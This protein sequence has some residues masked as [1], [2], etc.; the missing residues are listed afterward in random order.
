MGDC[1]SE[2][3]I[4]QRWIS[5]TEAALGLGIVVGIQDRRVVLSFPAAQEERTYA[6]DNAP[7][8]RIIYQIGDGVNNADGES[9]TITDVLDNNHMMIYKVENHLGE[10]AVL[11]ELDL[12]CFVNF[13]SPKDRLFSGILDPN[14]FF[15]LRQ[16]ALDY[17]QMYQ[18]SNVLGLLGP[19]VQLLPHQLYIAK[20]VAKQKAPRVLLADEVGLGK[21]IEAGLI[22][23][24]QL[25]AGLAE[26]VLILVPDSLLHQWLVEMLRRFNLRFSVFDED[27]CAE[28]HGAGDNPFE[29]AQYVLCPLSFLT[30]SKERLLQAL[31]CDWDLLLVDEAHHLEWSP[32]QS[33]IEYQTVEQLAAKAS[34]VLL[35]TATPEQLGLE[36]HFA[37]LHLLD[38]SRYYDLKVFIEEEAS[39]QP[40][41]QLL[42]K[43]MKLYME[44]GDL[45]SELEGYLLEGEWPQIQAI[46]KKDKYQAIEQVISTLL[47]RHG[48]GRILFR[49]TRAAITGFP[50]RQLHSYSLE[51]P[52]D[53]PSDVAA[54]SLIDDFLLESDAQSVTDWLQ[55]ERIFGDDWL[56][57]DLRV[58]WLFDFLEA[59]KKEKILLICNKAKSAIEL[60]E[61]LRI[62]GIRCAVF[63]EGM[64]LVNRDRAAAYFADSEDSAQLLVCSEIGSEGRNFQFSHHI[65]MFDLPLNP[66]LLEQRIGRLDRIGQT[67]AVNIHVPFYENTAQSV[68]FAW[69]HQGLNAFEHT[70]AIGRMVYAEHEKQLLDC[71][72][73][74]DET[75]MEQLL[76]ATQKT[77]KELSDTLHNGRDPLLELNSCRTDEA[78]K[79]IGDILAAEQ[80]TKLEDFIERSCEQFGID[81][82]VHSHSAII[83]RPGDH[84][85]SGGFVGLNEDGFTATF[86]RETAL[87]REDMQ[88]FTWEH[89]FVQSAFD[90]VLCSEH[91]NTAVATVKLKPLK[92]GTLLLEALFKV[93]TMAPKYLGLQRYLPSCHIRVLVDLTGRDFSDVLYPEKL[94]PLLQRLPLSTGQALVAQA[95]DRIE[96]LVNEAE[97]Q[98]NQ[99][100]PDFLD[101]ARQLAEQELQ[102]EIH[103]LQALAELN[104]QISTSQIDVLN[105]HLQLT[106]SSLLQASI[107]LDALRVIVAV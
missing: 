95:K 85:R 64:S 39:Y 70:C 21:T 45:P 48:T 33:S 102:D 27:I 40:I 37:R 44:H 34:G 1:V 31:A 7:L 86:S 56:Q 6:A 76:A 74:P 36:S 98:A 49:N 50:E 69:Y 68:L 105:E 71:L 51:L 17:W 106:Q 32:E 92:E 25:Q 46:F 35:L 47:D 93:E 84:M 4:G 55:I 30:G 60:E 62:S 19:R 24:Q 96:I 88:Y 11:S 101:Q 82:E 73:I 58:N 29:T 9:F 2:F 81:T 94:N 72:E 65:I 90:Q 78:S 61:H 54:E 18:Q 104:P 97:K 22:L 42:Q 28:L 99:Q 77:A 8:S 80:R 43:V 67:H 23:H 83:L 14:K 75:A 20:Q 15:E 52:L 89:P 41:N 100:L 103:R 57:I 91:G 16:D 66:D 13:N 59:H 53:M 79:I 87:S 3:Q 5:N 63:H 26:R 107:H 10:A 38:P 12:D